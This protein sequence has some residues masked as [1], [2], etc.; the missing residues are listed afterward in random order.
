MSLT[1]KW[2]SSGPV[3]RE[4]LREAEEKHK[5]VTIKKETEKVTRRG[6]S[7][8]EAEEKEKCVLPKS[9]DREIWRL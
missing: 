5:C 4:I 7:D 9:E 1:K 3:L 8:W 6:K 2:G